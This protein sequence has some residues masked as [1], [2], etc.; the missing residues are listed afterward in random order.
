MPPQSRQTLPCVAAV[1]LLL[2]LASAQ[3]PAS[4]TLAGVTVTPKAFGGKQC[5]GIIDGCNTC[6]R[7]L[8]L[9]NASVT[10][11]EGAKVANG[12]KYWRVHCCK[13]CRPGWD[14]HG[15]GDFYNFKKF[16]KYCIPSEGELSGWLLCSA[17]TCDSHPAAPVSSTA[18][19]KL[20]K[21]QQPLNCV[22]VEASDW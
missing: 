20:H 21:A 1:V 3:E 8:I 22:Y 6:L 17:C 9:R 15:D 10:M 4:V 12:G 16:P 5:F 14:L 2:A 13:V 7:Y 11:G 19:N 18:L